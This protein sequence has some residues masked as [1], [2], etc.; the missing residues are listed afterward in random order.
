MLKPSHFY[1]ILVPRTEGGGEEVLVFSSVQWRTGRENVV[2]TGTQ[3]DLRLCA[4]V[5]KY[6][7]WK[8]GSIRGPTYPP[9]SM[10]VFVSESPLH[11]DMASWAAGWSSLR[12][13]LR[14][15]DVSAS[16]VHGCT[17]LRGPT[18]RAPDPLQDQAP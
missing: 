2:Q 1:Y 7:C 5:Q 17:D 18:E 4:S 16:D 8:L 10:T 11:S 3:A 9:A 6:S 12:E 13:S 14:K 15:W